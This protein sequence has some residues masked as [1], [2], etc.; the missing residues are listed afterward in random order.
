MLKKLL[1]QK[2]IGGLALKRFYP[3]LDRHILVAATEM[4][5]VGELDAF[6]EALAG[7]LL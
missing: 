7:A 5:G 4:N 3:A 2:I 1:E 6:A